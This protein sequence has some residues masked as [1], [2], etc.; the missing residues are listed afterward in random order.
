M[1]EVFRN[2]NIR[3]IHV[4]NIYIPGVQEQINVTALTKDAVIVFNRLHRFTFS[5]KLL[6]DSPDANQNRIV[7]AFRQNVLNSC[8]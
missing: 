8:N 5:S 6:D 1:H 3:D 7:S 4:R 2:A